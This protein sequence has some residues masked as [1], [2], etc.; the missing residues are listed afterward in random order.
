[1]TSMGQLGIG[2]VERVDERTIT[3]GDAELAGFVNV[4]A[5]RRALSEFGGGDVYRVSLSYQGEDPRL[6]L[7]E[8]VPEL[9]ELQD[10]ISRLRKMEARSKSAW[11]FA[12]L[13]AVQ[14]NPGL[15]SAPLAELLGVDKAK[16]KPNVRKL[17]RLGLTVSLKV[18]Y[19]LSPRGEALLS[20]VA[21]TEN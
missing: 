10:L 16:L 8:E 13:L 14:A 5:V 1:M 12:T 2:T 11:V 9:G 15:G 21:K 4:E 7:R 17:K 20:A 6:A 18:G 19:R 3:Q